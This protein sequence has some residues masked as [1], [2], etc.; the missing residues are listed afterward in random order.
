MTDQELSELTRRYVYERDDEIAEQLKQQIQAE[1]ARRGIAL[2]K[3]EH[4]E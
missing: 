4:M 3:P 2:Y 1:Y